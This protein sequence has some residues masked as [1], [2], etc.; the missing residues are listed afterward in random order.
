[1]NQKEE[2]N[3]LLLFI[4]ESGSRIDALQTRALWTA[5]CLHNDLEIDTRK[6][7]DNL[8]RV[9][10]AMLDVEADKYYVFFEDYEEFDSYM[11]VY[12]V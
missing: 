10:K 2:F 7:D 9:Y 12:L 4:E 3:Y 1:M 11:G 8:K 5:Y 6:Y